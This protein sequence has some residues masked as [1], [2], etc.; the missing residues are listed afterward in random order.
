MYS[1]HCCLVITIYLRLIAAF[2]IFIHKKYQISV[3]HCSSDIFL[4]C[5]FLHFHYFFYNAVPSWIFFTKVLYTL[6]ETHIKTFDFDIAC[7]SETFFDLSIPIYN[8]RINF[9]GYSL[10]REDHQKRRLNT[11]RGD[12]CIN[13]KKI[14]PSIKRKDLTS[15]KECITT[16]I[17]FN[18]EK[19]FFIWICRSPKSWAWAAWFILF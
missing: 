19:C 4:D 11:K 18:N 3:T 17:M 8:Q 14:I 13:Y 10:L 7:L 6:T 16:E 2:V 15:L 5:T 12:T 9:K 1:V